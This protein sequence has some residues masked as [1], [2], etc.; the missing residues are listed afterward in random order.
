MGWNPQHFLAAIVCLT[1]YYIHLLLRCAGKSYPVSD[2]PTTSVIICF[3]NEAWSTLLRTVHS[4]LLRSPPE[5]LQEII[6]IDDFSTFGEH[7]LIVSF[8]EQTSDGKSVVRFQDPFVRSGH[9]K[10]H[11]SRSS[12]ILFPYLLLKLPLYTIFINGHLAILKI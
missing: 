3:H 2:L 9:S 5:L 6:L 1:W 7:S 8:P 11:F 4:V 10:T 12:K